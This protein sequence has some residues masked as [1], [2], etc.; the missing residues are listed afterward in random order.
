[1]EEKSVR[2]ELLALNYFGN[3]FIKVP[4]KLVSKMF[5]RNEAERS[6]GQLHFTLFCLCNHTDGFVTL[7]Y[8]YVKCR[9]GEFVGT[10]RMLSELS[11]LSLGTTV[12]QLNKL[13]EMNLIEIS[14]VV[15][16]SRITVCGYNDFTFLSTGVKEQASGKGEN[17]GAD[18]AARMKEAE[19]KIGGRRYPGSQNKT[20]N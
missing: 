17:P 10:Y 2:K 11:G 3:S 15:G 13:E 14:K 20:V 7:G 18:A 6:L 4:R 8:Y 1:M 16:G 5:S 12:R 9:R 19:D